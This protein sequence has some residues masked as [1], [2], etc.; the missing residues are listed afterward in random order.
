MLILVAVTITV[1]VNGGLFKHAGQ[2]TG[3]TKNAINKEQQLASG[4]INI[5]GVWYNS[6]QDYVDEKPSADQSGTSGGENDSIKEPIEE[7]QAYAWDKYSFNLTYIKNGTETSA[8]SSSLT[9]M[10]NTNV[11]N[12]TENQPIT[13]YSKVKFSNNTFYVWDSW[14][15][16]QYEYLYN[17]YLKYPFMQRHSNEYYTCCGGCYIP[18]QNYLTYY[19]G[20][21]INTGFNERIDGIVFSD[22]Y[23][24]GTISQG[25]YKY[26]TVTSTDSS[27]YPTNDFKDGYWYVYKG[28]Q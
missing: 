22:I 3:E 21:V 2:A 28:V 5:D 13:A 12:S 24:L 1:A 27:A 26:E 4:R 7:G 25:S 11:T 16:N 18:A 9:M 14:T 15:G 20:N 10:R 23:S 19:Y 17:A 6:M 8:G